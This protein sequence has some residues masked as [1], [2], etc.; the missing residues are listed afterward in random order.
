MTGCTFVKIRRQMHGHPVPYRH[1]VGATL[2]AQ[3]GRTLFGM[4][5]PVVWIECLGDIV[6]LPDLV[7]C[8]AGATRLGFSATGRALDFHFDGDFRKKTHVNGDF[9]ALVFHDFYF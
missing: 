1:T 4:L 2:H 6:A 5:F 7:R 3:D 8:T 9:L